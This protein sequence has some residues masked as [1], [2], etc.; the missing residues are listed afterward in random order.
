MT[1]RIDHIDIAK[2]ISIFL[3]ALHHSRFESYAELLAEPLSLARMPFFFF[4]SG[5]FFS[6]TPDFR[7]FALKRAD[8]LLKPYFVTLLGLLLVSIILGQ[9]QLMHQL[10]GT[11]YGNGDTIRWPALWF[12]THLFALHC[13][14][15]LVYRVSGFQKFSI[16]AKAFVLASMLLAGASVLGLFRHIDLTVLGQQLALPGLPFGADLLPI[17]A[18]FF[19]LGQA[20]RERAIHF[21]PDGKLVMVSLLVFIGV[22][23]FTSTSIDLNKRIFL[24]PPLALL[25]ALGA[26]Y[27]LLALAW[28]I[29]KF[30]SLK[31]P[32]LA[33]GSGS[34]FILIFHVSIEA[35]VFKGLVNLLGSTTPRFAMALVS[36]IACLALPLLIKRVATKYAWLG[37]L[38][39][40]MRKRAKAN[41][42]SSTVNATP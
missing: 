23:V 10:W 17:S 27:V 18:A 8:A 25:G 3:V 32:F 9:G 6:Y 28:F 40:P 33:M 30:P 38:Y 16:V 37:V 29:G 5:I 31:I 1:N 2:G 15:Y 26:I 41:E 12:L 14:S 19:L 4:L 13:F 34:L 21:E 11:L 39:L 24:N 36:L 20:L 22:T 7:Q 42:R 35:R